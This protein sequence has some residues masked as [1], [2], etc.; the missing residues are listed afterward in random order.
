MLM[1]N[2]VKIAVSLLLAISLTACGSA[3]DSETNG[4]L[5]LSASGEDTGA[6]TTLM[7][8][9]A[10]ITPGGGTTITVLPGKPGAE[11]D[12][13]YSQYG[14]DSSGYIQTIV[15]PTTESVLTDSQGTATFSKGFLQSQDM[16]TTIQVTAKFGGLTSTTVT[17]PVLKY[18]P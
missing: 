7:N 9:T 2:I 15:P 8:A 5:T 10:T 4:T 13:T 16:A 1:K 17:I 3:G 12:F 14:T 18:V 6:G 11:I